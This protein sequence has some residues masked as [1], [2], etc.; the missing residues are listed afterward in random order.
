MQVSTLLNKKYNI[1]III[2]ELVLFST[3]II[4]SFVNDVISR[5]SLLLLMLLIF[6]VLVF[7]YGFEE[8]NHYLNNKLIFTI[9]SFCSAYHIGTVLL[10]FFTGFEYNSNPFNFIEIIKNLIPYLIFIVVSELLRYQ[11]ALKGQKNKIIL[12]LLILTM[13]F[14]ECSDLIYKCNFNDIS[15]TIGLISL[16]VLP[17]LFKN[18]FLT[19]IALKVGYKS[20]IVYRMF[21]ELP[22]LFLPIIPATGI[23]LQSIIDLTFPMLLLFSLYSLFNKKPIIVSDKDK[24]IN[25]IKSSIRVIISSIIIINVALVRGLFMYSSLVVGSKSMEPEFFKG[26]IIIVKKLSKEEIKTLSVGEILVFTRSNVIMSHRIREISKTKDELYFYTKGDSNDSLDPFVT[27]EPN[28][29]GIV[30][31]TIP[32]IGGATVYLKELTNF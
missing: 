10:G 27:K 30:V 5:F 21:L 7:I 11:I 22:L 14:S 2:A 26:D 18:F 19:Y 9:I 17:S 28:I 23:Y 31:S 24:K 4:D 8:D 1:Y 13:T 32:K 29:I 12:T 16:K 6:V 20:T 15:D 3:L 25:K